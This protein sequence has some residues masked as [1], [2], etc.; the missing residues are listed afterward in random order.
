MANLSG[1]NIGTNYKGIL[2]LGST[3]NT[4]L[5]GTLQAI[6]D[7]DGNASPLQLSSS[8]ISVGSISGAKLAVKGNGSSFATFSFIVQN[9][10]G[11]N[12]LRIR[13]DGQIFAEGGGAFSSAG[14]TG[15]AYGLFGPLAAYDASAVVVMGSTT[16]GFLPP[17]M[18][19]TQRD[20]IGSPSEGLVVYN[21]T[22]KVLN[23]YNGSV[24]AAV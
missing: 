4:A 1:Q 13:D 15:T 9:S 5:S 17:K 11:A 12:L 18:T 8:E 23:F 2:N 24:W 22:T 20:A 10:S 7:G 6:T 21:T 19:T 16:Q 3:I 14:I